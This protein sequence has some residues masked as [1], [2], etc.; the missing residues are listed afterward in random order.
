MQG[1]SRRMSFKNLPEVKRKIAKRLQKDA[2]RNLKKAMTKSAL[3]VRGEAVSS[4]L[5]G[6]KSGVTYRKYN[7]NRTHTASAKGQA[8]A[9]DTGTLA[10]G[11]SHEVV[12]EGRNVVGKITA[13]ASDGGGDNYAKHLEFGT[14]NMSARPFMQPALNKNAKKIQAIFKRE[15]II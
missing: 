15:G 7:P 3:L 2:P 8:P 14:V 12:M 1:R 5:S 4:I 13:F 9:S 6:N 10:S 11:I